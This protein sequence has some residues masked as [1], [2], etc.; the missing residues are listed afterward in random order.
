M[1]SGR[2]R[3]GGD[4]VGGLR[5]FIDGPFRL[6]FGLI[7]V[8]WKWG[9]KAIAAKEGGRRGRRWGVFGLVTVCRARWSE[10][11]RVG[12]YGRNHGR[13]GEGGWFAVRGGWVAAVTRRS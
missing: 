4:I 13:W 10:E 6:A 2:R 3:E 9:G 5:S 12:G 8:D 11:G 7:V 1:R